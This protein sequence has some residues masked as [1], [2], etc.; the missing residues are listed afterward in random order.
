[1]TTAQKIGFILI[2]IGGCL[3]TAA[4]PFISEF[5]P[6]PELCLTSNF[7]TNMGNMMLAFGSS[8]VIPYRYLFA[9][10]VI[11]VCSGLAVIVVYYPA[12]TKNNK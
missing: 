5:R 7:F 8:F 9:L 4:L 3:P 2:I 11:L 10:G 6:H 1:M 12:V